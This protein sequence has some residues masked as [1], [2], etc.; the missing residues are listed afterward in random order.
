[1]PALSQ[2]GQGRHRGGVWRTQLSRQAPCSMH[3]CMVLACLTRA[4]MSPHTGPRA[5]P[6]AGPQ[7]GDGGRMCDVRHAAAGGADLQQLRRGVWALHLHDLQGVRASRAGG[8]CSAARGTTPG[9]RCVGSARHTH[10]HPHIH[11]HTHRAT[12]RA[13]TQFFDDDVSKQQFHCDDCGI[14]RVGGRQNFFHCATCGCCYST[15]CAGL[16][17]PWCRQW[18]HMLP[19]MRSCPP[20]GHAG[21]CCLA[22]AACATRTCASATACAATAQCA[23]STCSTPSGPSLFWPAATPSTRCA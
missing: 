5:S 21:C 15:R 13:P 2:P 23:W 12:S 9:P 17:V 14:C 6:P 10:P 7:G 22:C 18:V 19:V 16:L 11:T 8:V 1:M 3:A 20:D 4:W